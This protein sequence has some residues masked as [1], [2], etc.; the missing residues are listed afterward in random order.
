MSTITSANGVITASVQGLFPSPVTLEGWA[1]DDAFALDEVTLAEA[2]IG[3]DGMAAYGYV[4]TLSPFTIR[5]LANSP[6]L[7]FFEEIVNQTMALGEVFII[8][9][10]VYLPSVGKRYVFSNGTLLSGKLMPDGKKTLAD[11]DFKMTFGS[12]TS[13]L[14]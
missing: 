7:F 8:N 13:Y 3:V 2:K 6:S 4:P 10:T 9:L 14:V 1:V 11:Q 12:I 5:L